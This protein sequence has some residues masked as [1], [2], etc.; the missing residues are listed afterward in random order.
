MDQRLYPIKADF[1][2]KEIDRKGALDILDSA[3][4][5]GMT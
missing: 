2:R 1:F 5:A 3:T 4:C